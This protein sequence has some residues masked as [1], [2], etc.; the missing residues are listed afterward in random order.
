MWAEFFKS[1]EVSQLLMDESDKATVM[2]ALS[3]LGAR[4]PMPDVALLRGGE[5]KRL[6]VVADK[7]FAVGYL[8]I[9]PMVPGINK[10]S[11]RS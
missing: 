5:E 7:C 10:L 6:R 9:A 11:I 3:R 4:L 2:A 8:V 1:N